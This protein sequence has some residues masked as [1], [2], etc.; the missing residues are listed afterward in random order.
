[1]LAQAQITN[2]ECMAKHQI[3]EQE[4]INNPISTHTSVSDMMMV[5]FTPVC[6]REE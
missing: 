2:Y 1:M 5:V 6:D 4:K 3:V